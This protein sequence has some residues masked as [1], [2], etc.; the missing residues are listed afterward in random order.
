MKNDVYHVNPQT[1]SYDC[2]LS[3]EEMEEKV[4][5]DCGYVLKNRKHYGLDSIQ[6]AIGEWVATYF[7]NKIQ[8]NF[9][10]TWQEYKNFITTCDDYSLEDIM[11]KYIDTDLVKNDIKRFIKC[12]KNR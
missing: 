1:L 2:S 7:I 10:G 3:P 8:T 12:Y 11:N 6:Y 9:L 5:R 4:T